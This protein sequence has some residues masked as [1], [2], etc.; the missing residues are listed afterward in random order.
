MSV[1]EACVLQTVK[2]CSIINPHLFFMYVMAATGQEMVRGKILQGYGC[3]NLVCT[4]PAR[5]R[6]ILYHRLQHSCKYFIC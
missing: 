4:I 2:H 1:Q 5:Q 3:G 6:F